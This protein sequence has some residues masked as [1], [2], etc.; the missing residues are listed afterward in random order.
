[1]LGQE[2]QKITGITDEVMMSTVAAT[3]GSA[4]TAAAQPAADAKAPDAKDDKGAGKPE[5]AAGVCVV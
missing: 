1:M 4:G 2:M 5:K 3:T